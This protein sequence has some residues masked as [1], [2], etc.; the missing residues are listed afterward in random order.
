MP[1]ERCLVWHAQLLLPAKDAP[2]ADGQPE[3][4]RPS[5]QTHVVALASGEVVKRR[6]EVLIGEDAEVHLEAVEEPDAA[7]AVSL[8]KDFRHLFLLGQGFQDGTCVLGRGDDVHVGD[9]LAEASHAARH[10]DAQHAGR[11][12]QLLAQSGGHWQDLPQ[13][14][15]RMRGAVALE[16]GEQPR[17][18]LLPEALQRPD[19]S[20][21]ES[22]LQARQ[23]PDAEGGEERLHLA[24]PEVR[25]LEEFQNA[26]RV[27]G[28]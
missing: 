24:R 20:L 11:F 13:T 17:L 4:P 6:G 15:A 28:A 7:L 22:L 21:P 23:V 10:L 27:G 16:P 3:F 9:E 25:Q 14:T 18:A 5:P 8:S 2:L 26:R 12:P 1:V 19:A